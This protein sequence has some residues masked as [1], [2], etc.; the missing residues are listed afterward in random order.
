MRAVSVEYT[1]EQLSSSGLTRGSIR[2]LGWGESS[3]AYHMT[4]PD[5]S[6]AGAE[7]AIRRAIERAEISTSDVGYINLHGT[8][9]K[10][11]DSMESK[12]VAAIFGENTVPVS[13]TKAVTGHTLGAAAALEAAICWKAL[14]ENNGKNID[15]RNLPLQVW[16]GVKDDELP[17]LNIVDKNNSGKTSSV[18]KDFTVCLSNSFAFGG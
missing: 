12:A 9:T 11:N 2:L 15:N 14:V 3:D 8:G 5:P 10:L 17:S 16:D 6:G 4:S 1:F 7:K 13:S 18:S